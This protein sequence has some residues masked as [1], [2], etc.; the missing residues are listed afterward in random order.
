MN[1]PSLP[2]LSANTL[3]HFTASL[4]NLLNI[5]TSVFSPRFCLEDFNLLYDV[6]VRQ[7]E[8]EWAVPMVCFFDLPLSHTAFHLHV[9][10]HYGIGLTKEWGKRNGIAPVLYAYSKSILTSNMIF[11]ISLVL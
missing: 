8:L 10:G 5:L 1:P 11:T 3:F 6:G 9:Y 4:D 7:E 2:P